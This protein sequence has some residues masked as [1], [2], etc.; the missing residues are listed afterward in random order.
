MTSRGWRRSSQ[1]E[2]ALRIRDFSPSAA[3]GNTLGAPSL[4]CLRSSA[5]AEIVGEIDRTFIDLQKRL[6]RGPFG[7]DHV[8]VFELDVEELEFVVFACVIAGDRRAVDQ[9]ADCQ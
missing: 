9:A 1:G 3:I 7:I 5:P 2:V 4:F 6:D 8:M